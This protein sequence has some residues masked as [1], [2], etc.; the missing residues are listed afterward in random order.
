MPDGRKQQPGGWNRIVLWVDDLK[1][2]VVRL[3][4]ADVHF[5]NEIEGVPEA[6]RS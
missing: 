3:T 5:R 6:R 4:Q 2:E 1:A